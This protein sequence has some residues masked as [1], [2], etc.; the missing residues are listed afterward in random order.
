MVEFDRFDPVHDAPSVANFVP[1]VELLPDN[2]LIR[3][4]RIPPM[5]AMHS[6]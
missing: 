5:P 1:V 2:G 6:A 4:V 3:N